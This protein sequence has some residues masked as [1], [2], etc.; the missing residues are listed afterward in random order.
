MEQLLA[1]AIAL[2]NAGDKAGTRA[3]CEQLLQQAPPHPAVHQLMAVLLLD[4]GDALQAAQQADRSLQLRPGHA[5]TM[6]IAAQ[7]WFAASHRA[8]GAG[9]VKA[10]EHAL[11]RVLALWPD[12]IEACVNLGILLQ[13]SHRLEEAMPWY[14]RAYRLRPDS[15]GRIANALC[16]EPNGALWTDLQAMREALSAA[17]A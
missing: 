16:S 14:G 9:D 15:F 3:L 6:K 13:A 17:A 11:R 7:A 10:E 2:Y 4:E 12:H 5:P 1:R 8:L